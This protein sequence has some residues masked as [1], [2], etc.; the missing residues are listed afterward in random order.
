[1]VFVPGTLEYR[2][3]VTQIV[4]AAVAFVLLVANKIP[5]KWAESF[6]KFSNYLFFGWMV[7]GG[8]INWVITGNIVFI[9]SY[10]FPYIAIPMFTASVMY[11]YKNWREIKQMKQCGSG[12]ISV[13]ARGPNG[14]G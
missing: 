8:T 5:M 10:L 6:Y 4:V 12:E 11:A 3:L 2:L 14:Q 9:I 1:M 13:S 7:V